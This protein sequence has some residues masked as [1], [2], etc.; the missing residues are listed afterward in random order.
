MAAPGA[1]MPR[2]EATGWGVRFRV[3]RAR[4]HDDRGRAGGLSVDG[5][6]SQDGPVRQEMV[7]GILGGLRKCDPR[8]AAGGIWLMLQLLTT[9]LGP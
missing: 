2:V 8:H 4:V 5:A 9:P 6:T 1:T 7:D 3:P